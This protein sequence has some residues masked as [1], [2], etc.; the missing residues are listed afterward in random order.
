MTVEEGREVIK[1]IS[2]TIV[3]IV[4]ESEYSGD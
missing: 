1:Y 2:Q 4:V 3:Y